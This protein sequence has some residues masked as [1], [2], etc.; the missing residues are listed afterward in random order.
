MGLSLM[1]VL[2]LSGAGLLHTDE[3]NAHGYV[4]KPAARGYQGSLDKNTI[5]WGPAME[6]YGMVITNPQS[7]EFDKGFPQAGP[8]DGHI[9]SAQGG[10]G[11]ITDSVMDSTGANRWTKQD[12]N[13]GVNTFSWHYTAPH[14]T[15]KWHYYMTKVGWNPE[16][17][18]T[19]ADFD[20]LGEVKHD[21][22][23]ASN[24]KSHQIV[25]PENRLGYHVILAVWDVEDTDNAFYN[26][27]DVNVKGNGE[28]APPIEEAPAT[29]TSV[30]ASEVTTSSL[31][32]TWNAVSTVKEYNVYRDGKKVS[33]VGG[34]QFNDTNLAE[35][36]TYS[37]Q[38]EA[39]GTNGKIS[40]KSTS[41]K[42]TT[43]SS[44]VEDTQ[45]PTAPANVHSMETTENSVDLMWTKSTHFLGVKNY[46]V[47]RD[48]K[49]VATTKKTNVKDTRLE[50]DTTYNYTIRAVSLGGNISDAS[51]VFSVKTKEA[52]SGH[53]T[54][55][56]DTI[57]NYG[58]R[59][60]FDNLEY[61]ARWWTKGERPDKS[62]VWKLLS[63]KSVNWETSKAYS[64]GDTVVFQGETYEAKWWTQ[65]NQPGTAMVWD[66]VES[67]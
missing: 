35:N 33:T 14:S 10:K 49:K 36:T 23:L 65:G 51:I 67:N 18:L 37:Y 40:E 62:D 48:G 46:E 6:K 3:A 29:P 38:V 19:R 11:Q 42:V 15:T 16:K 58:D 12:I 41:I 43:Q 26:V 22:S 45:N 9:A 8:A 53:S 54:W 2:I 59:V 27:I 39:V 56:A 20:F 55:D 66:L 63:N 25:V 17:P 31:K 52:P 61:E 32:L 64:G 13:T 60:I 7:L 50:A 57:Y 34:T 4:E 21:G 28:I 1:S 47:Y 30:N 5:G 24:N 44:E